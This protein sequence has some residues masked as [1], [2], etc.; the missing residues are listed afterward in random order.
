VRQELVRQS[1]KL[2]DDLHFWMQDYKVDYEEYWNR[3]WVGCN[4]G[5]Y[6]DDF[7]WNVG[8]SGYCS[9]FTHYGN[10]NS[11]YE[12]PNVIFKKPNPDHHT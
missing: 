3:K 10:T 11:V 9:N 1:S 6:G 4:D 2:L 8:L 7:E 5:I 12:N